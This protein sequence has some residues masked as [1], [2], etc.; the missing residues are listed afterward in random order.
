MKDHEIAQLVNELTKIA[1]QF[2]DHQSLRQRISQVVNNAL[3]Q[4]SKE[5]LTVVMEQ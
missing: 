1:T 2:H 3:K 4:K 5:T